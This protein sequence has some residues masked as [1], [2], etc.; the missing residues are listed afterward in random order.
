MVTGT[1]S[2]QAPHLDPAAIHCAQTTR[3]RRRRTPNPSLTGGPITDKGALRADPGGARHRGRP[4]GGAGGTRP[5]L[6]GDGLDAVELAVRSAM[7][8]V[9]RSLLEK[10]LS[11]EDGA[12]MSVELVRGDRRPASGRTGWSAAP[13]SEGAGRY[14]RAGPRRGRQREQRC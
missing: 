2:L 4:P 6:W 3:R 1:A 5:R 8:G 14:R 7:I 12:F 11:I 13:V 9:G 10:L